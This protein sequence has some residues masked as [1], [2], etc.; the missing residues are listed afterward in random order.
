M[1]DVRYSTWSLT[2]YFNTGS[3]LTLKVIIQKTDSFS[4]GYLS[5]TTTR[6]ACQTICWNICNLSKRLCRTNVLS[7]FLRYSTLYSLSDLNEYDFPH[8][9]K[10][11]RSNDKLGDLVNPKQY[12]SHTTLSLFRVHSVLVGIL[13]EYCTSCM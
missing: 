12:V 2:P 7:D 10:A 11:I 3:T 4:L 9:C 6:P 1:H 13:W 5:Y 8:N